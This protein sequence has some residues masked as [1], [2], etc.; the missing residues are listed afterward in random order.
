MAERQLW[1]DEKALIRSKVAYDSDVVNINVGGTMHLQTEKEVLQSVPGS[2]LQKLFSDMH[3]LKIIDD[4]V[5]LDRD[6]KT[7]E[8][9][10]NYLR[11]DR[12]VFPEFADKNM[13][14]NF[15]KELHYWGIDREHRQW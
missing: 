15:Y 12:K 5:F 2:T 3:E 11:N 7:F 4:E 8:A 6:G 9:L 1:E 13:E 10:V 14:N